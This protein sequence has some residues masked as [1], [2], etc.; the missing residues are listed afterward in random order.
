MVVANGKKCP[1]IQVYI[2]GVQQGLTFE[3]VLY[4]IYFNEIVT[5]D[6]TTFAANS[7]LAN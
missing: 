3:P 4:Q 6:D 2:S 7:A 1:Q 5:A